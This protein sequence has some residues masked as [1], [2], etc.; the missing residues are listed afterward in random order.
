MLNTRPTRTSN[1]QQGR[2]DRIFWSSGA[3]ARHPQPFLSR[4]WEFQIPY[5]LREDYG[6]PELTEE[7]KEKILGKNQ[8]AMLGWDL[9]EV[10]ARVQN[11]G[12]GMRKELAE[13]WSA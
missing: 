12:I 1:G 7:I 5:R 4:F 13:P 10:R 3:T 2:E 11:D 6:Y 9:D 8:A